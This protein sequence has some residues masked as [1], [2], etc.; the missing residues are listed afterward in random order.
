L[1]RGGMA[2]VIAAEGHGVSADTGVIAAEGQGDVS[3]YTQAQYNEAS[4]ASSGA[5][6]YTLSIM[7]GLVFIGYFAVLSV[8]MSFCCMGRSMHAYAVMHEVEAQ[9]KPPQLQGPVAELDA[10]WRKQFIVK[11]YGILCIQLAMTVTVCF[12]MMQFGGYQLFMWTM[13]D[14]YWT[15][16]ASFIFTLATLISLMCYKNR[17]P[18]NILLLGLF[19]LSMSY[20]IGTTCTA[21]AALGYS[22]VVVEAFAITSLLFVGL[23]AFVMVSKID[24]SFLGLVLPVLFLSLMIFGL[25]SLLAFDSFAMRQVYALLGCLLFVLYILYDTSVIITYLSYDDYVLGAVNLYLD[26]INLFMFILQ[27]LMGGRRE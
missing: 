23:T 26:F 12:G 11:V 16:M 15:K 18:L 20:L 17:H 3:S 13:T 1:A 24:F 27:L 2:E 8:Y 4:Y 22:V 25:F 21:Y 10:M 5:N 7:M 14:G 19:T 6:Q 9:P